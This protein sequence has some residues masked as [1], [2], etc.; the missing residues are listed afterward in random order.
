MLYGI[1]VG[2]IK[3]VFFASLWIE[4]CSFTNPAS[5]SLGFLEDSFDLKKFHRDGWIAGFV[6]CYEDVCLSELTECGIMESFQ[7]SQ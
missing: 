6:Y 2:E 7:S 5:P 3:Q 1:I 4:V